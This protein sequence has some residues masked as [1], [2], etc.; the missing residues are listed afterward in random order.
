M[1]G[2]A[3]AAGRHAHAHAGTR[4]ASTHVWRPALSLLGPAACLLDLTTTSMG[5]ADTSTRLG[6]DT[7]TSTLPRSGERG[8]GSPRWA[9][10]GSARDTGAT[11]TITGHQAEHTYHTG[12]HT[13]FVREC[14][15]GRRPKALRMAT[16][17]QT[18]RRPRGASR[19]VRGHRAGLQLRCPSRRPADRLSRS[20][21]R[22]RRVR[23]IDTR[24]AAPSP[25]VEVVRGVT[26]AAT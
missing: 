20:T 10:T 12:L 4:T 5:W 2:L 13:S 21:T 3:Y 25:A 16:R 6:R 18:P 24:A 22:R 14:G 7:S 1:L 11:P 15:R 26:E 19:R 8:S 9:R 23:Q 17:P